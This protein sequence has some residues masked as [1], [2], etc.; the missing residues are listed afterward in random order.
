MP[1]IFPS[2][3]CGRVRRGGAKGV[4]LNI[5]QLQYFCKLAELQHYTKAAEQLYITQPTLSNSIARLEEELGV[6]LFEKSGR[7]VRLTKYGKEFNKYA[8]KALNALHEG[9]DILKEQIGQYSGTV[10][11]GTIYTIQD[12]YIPH[13]IREFRAKFGSGPLIDLYQGLTRSLIEGLEA[14]AY[15]VAF[16]AFVDGK[17]HLAFVPVLRQN[18]VA[19]I[20]KDNPLAEKRML[21]FDDFDGR[22]LVTYREDT[23]L[24]GEVK[25][26]LEKHD[27]VPSERCDD[28]ITLASIVAA[29]ENSIGL[30]LDTVGASLFD[31]LTVRP[32]EEVPDGF[33]T[34]YLVYKKG[35]YRSPTVEHFIELA[36]QMKYEK[37]SP[38]IDANR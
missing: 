36:T 6:P 33:H 7:N 30:S 3:G 12:C 20:R 38:R 5:S 15:D 23:S 10:S 32:V 25:S 16:T 34:V 11:V 28:E 31:E 17:D 26:L 21:S 2:H 22:S 24:G 4:L 1:C 29:G 19:I 8:T 9:S 37:E 13:L 27:V 35:I 18:L 14:D